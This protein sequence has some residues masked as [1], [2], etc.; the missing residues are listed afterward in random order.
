MRDQKYQKRMTDSKNLSAEKNLRTWHPNVSLLG[1]DSR[2]ALQGVRIGRYGLG[3]NR[4]GDVI[5]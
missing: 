3:A 4:T 1:Y 2:K 5:K